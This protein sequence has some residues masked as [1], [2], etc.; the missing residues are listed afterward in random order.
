M[1]KSTIFETLN[2]YD[3]EICEQTGKLVNALYTTAMYEGSVSTVYHSKGNIDWRKKIIAIEK[4]L[5]SENIIAIESYNKFSKLTLRTSWI[6]GLIGE[7]AWRE[8][9]I[10]Y[11]VRSMRLPTKVGKF[12]GTKVHGKLADTGLKRP[13]FERTLASTFSFDR[14]MLIKYERPIIMNIFKSLDKIQDK[15]LKQALLDDPVS[16]WEICR[17]LVRE[18]AHSTQAHTQGDLALDQRGRAILEAIRYAFSP[19]TN[20][21]ARASIVIPARAISTRNYKAIESIYLFIA[22]LIGNK[23]TNISEKIEE[24]ERCYH[25]GVLPKL[26][27]FKASDRKELHE[28]IFFFYNYFFYSV[29]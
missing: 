24:G 16:Y 27:L 10:A 26:K 25:E 28:L 8:E 21:D 13:G 18:Y 15:A 11:K 6:I 5:D 14:N 17:L 4:A 23:T 2:A 7:D 29:L 20:K 19:I 9:R 22:E 3:I 12:V 1:I